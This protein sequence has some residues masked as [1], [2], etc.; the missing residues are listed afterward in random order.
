M[1]RVARNWEQYGIAVGVTTP[2][3]PSSAGNG[4][5]QSAPRPAA[6]TSPAVAA[7]DDLG[8]RM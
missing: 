6:P 7:A 5:A 8:P 3:A 2:A 1:D 4:T